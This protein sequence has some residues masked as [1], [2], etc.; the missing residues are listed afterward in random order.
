MRKKSI[1]QLFIIPLIAVMLIQA[2]ISFGTVISSGTTAMLDEYSVGILGQ[3]VENRRIIL[4][5]H[6]VYDWSNVSEEV[7]QANEALAALLERREIGMPDFQGD[8]DLHRELLREMLSPC[9]YMLRRNAV[10]GAFVVLTDT[11]VLGEDQDCEGVYFRDMDPNGNPADYSD[12]LMERG[13]SSFSRELNI[14]LDSY[15]T[16]SFHFAAQGERE[17]DAFFYRPLTAALENPGQNYKNLAYWSQ[18][19]SLERGETIPDAYRM[20]TYTAPLVYEDGTVY[21]V[22]GVELSEHYLTK[23]LPMQEL[24]DR[25]QNG[26][27]LARHDRETGLTPL[28]AS[29]AVTLRT[30]KNGAISTEETSFDEFL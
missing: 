4:E 11:G 26:Y 23:L 16:T 15:W 5:N 29:G 8:R 10:T 7:S 18:P 21:G 13:N 19:F 6:M 30:G 27:L 28:V 9:L 22:I 12:V 17:E 24:G 2:A 25:G 3:T 1:F 14:P 20:I